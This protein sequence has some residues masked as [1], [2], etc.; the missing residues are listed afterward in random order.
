MSYFSA[1]V[2]DAKR[3]GIRNRKEAIDEASAGIGLW[4]RRSFFSGHG[5]AYHPPIGGVQPCNPTM[6]GQSPGILW[7]RPSIS[8]VQGFSTLS[9]LA[10]ARR[11]A[12]DAFP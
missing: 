9:T 12:L 5:L 8:L 6:I 2:T 7:R 3:E 11:N 4:A 1:R 10:A